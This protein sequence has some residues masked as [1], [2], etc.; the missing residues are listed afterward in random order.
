M[1]PWNANALTPALYAHMASLSLTWLLNNA[2]SVAC[3]TSTKNGTERL[4]FSGLPV[5]T[6]PG[7][8]RL[9]YQRWDGYIG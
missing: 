8:R 6:P 4:P 7:T 9:W 2:A 1:V 5:T 3:G